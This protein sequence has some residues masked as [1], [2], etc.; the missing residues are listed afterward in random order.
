MNQLNLQVIVFTIV[1]S[2]TKLLINNINSCF[3]M[4]WRQELRDDLYIY[5]YLY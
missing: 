5:I 3:D 1:A 2:A 4:N